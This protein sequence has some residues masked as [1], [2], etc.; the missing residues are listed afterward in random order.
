MDP[1]SVAVGRLDYNVVVAAAA[2][3]RS[4]DVAAAV[5]VDS[6]VVAVAQRHFRE[7][8]NWDNPKEFAVVDNPSFVVVVDM[9][10]VVAAV[11]VHK[12]IDWSRRPR[13]WDP[14]SSGSC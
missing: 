2:S 14:D 1:S 8:R 6:D 10:S 3:A 5:V 13:D 4:S 7:A 12:H 11:A 9:N